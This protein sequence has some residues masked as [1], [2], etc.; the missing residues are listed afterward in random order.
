MKAL[1]L[2][3]GYGVRLYPLT[4]NK[5]KPLLAIAGRPVIEW[6][7]DRI[8]PL[9]GV[10]EI[11][12]VVNEQFYENYQRWLGEYG[13][14]K[15][16]TLCNDHT[17]SN[18]TRL[19]AIGDINLVIDEHKIKDDLLIIAGDNL[20]EFNLVEFVR[21]FKSHG[22]T[23]ALRNMKGV[24]KRLISQYSVVTL[25]KRDQVV[26]F[27]EK[28]PDPKSSLIAICLY[29]F[30]KKDLVLIK[31]YLATGFNP[32]AP[33]YYIQWLYK[34]TDVCG[35]IMKGSWFDIGDIDSYNKANDYYKR[36]I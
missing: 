1:I 14:S 3:A 19:G 16:I 11:I 13:C 32:D 15:K 29:L 6:V 18:E 35:C 7:I 9:K 12:I 20:F 26:D 34:K 2:G 5:P 36:F 28:P 22:P 31:K 24:D 27:E 30:P 8:L 25:D 17:D 33:G 10:D 23:I 21:F 4:K